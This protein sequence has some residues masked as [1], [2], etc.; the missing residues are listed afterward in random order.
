MLGAAACRRLFARLTMPAEQ[1]HVLR[2]FATWGTGN[3]SKLPP[4]RWP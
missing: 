1:G 4:G 3:R 2:T